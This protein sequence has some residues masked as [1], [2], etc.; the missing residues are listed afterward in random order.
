MIL[1]SLKNYVLY[2]NIS[3]FF[4]EAFDFLK[5]NK[6]NKI[7][8]GNYEIK[9]NDV[10]VKIRDY[11]TKN[12]DL[13]VWESHRDYIDIHYVIDGAE[14]IGYSNIFEMKKKEYI[15]EKDQFVLQGLGDYF[16]L[17]KGFFSI[18]FPCDAHMPAVHL[19]KP[20]KVKKAIIKVS[21]KHL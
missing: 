18:F 2:K 13:A 5:S 16:I 4:M 3:P 7:K 21:C 14:Y 6:L 17:N 20:K 12:K 1:D 11:E 9:G 8:A 15:I 10:F 19:Y